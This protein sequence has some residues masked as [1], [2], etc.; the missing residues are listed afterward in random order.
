MTH[1]KAEQIQ[2]LAQADLLLLTSKLLLLP[3]RSQAPELEVSDAELA[4]L[5]ER[6][7]PRGNARL[8]ILFSD[9]LTQARRTDIETWSNEHCRLFEGSIQCPANETAYV[10]RDKGAILADICGFYIAF[11]F[12]APQMS[13][14]KAD[15]VVCELEFTAMLLTLLALARQEDNETG[16]QV[17]RDALIE[18]AREHLGEW[19][20]LFCDRLVESAQLPLYEKVGELLPAVWEVIAKSQGIPAAAGNLSGLPPPEPGTPYECDMAE[21][22]GEISTASS[23]PETSRRTPES[24]LGKV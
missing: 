21:L 5:L 19:L 18:F 7:D 16:E 22:C 4:D 11:G 8:P 14:E 12:E 3:D 6:A 24:F 9:V 2:T 23:A 10:R 13:A 1:W 15:H 17:T 20:G